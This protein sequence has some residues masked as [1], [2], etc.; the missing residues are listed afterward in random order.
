LKTAFEKAP[1]DEQNVEPFYFTGAGL[2]LWREM[3][4]PLKNFVMHHETHVSAL[5][6]LSAVHFNLGEN[7]LAL[8]EAN[9]ALTLDPKN[10][11]A[12]SI[13]E[14]VSKMAEEDPSIL[15]VNKTE[16][17]LSLDINSEILPDLLDGSPLV[18]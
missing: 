13:A 3:V 17:G 8:Q 12:R 1:D 11:I 5:S 7:A 14:R 18:W 4:E 15:S 6:R 9:K 10:P 16:D 2:G